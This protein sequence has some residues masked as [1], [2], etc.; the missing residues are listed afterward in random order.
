MNKYYEYKCRKQINYIKLNILTNTSNLASTRAMKAIK[1]ELPLKALVSG[2][3]E[4]VSH[5]L[6]GEFLGVG[7]GEGKTIRIPRYILAKLRV[8][9]SL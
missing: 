1:V 2:L 3:I 9:Y 8:R 5:Y 6:V 7:N 4:E